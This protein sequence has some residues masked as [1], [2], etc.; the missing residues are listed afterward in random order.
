MR[1]CRLRSAGSEA[2]VRRGDAATKPAVPC[3]NRRRERW[4]RWDMMGFHEVASRNDGRLPS[5]GYSCHGLTSR[6]RY[7]GSN[8]QGDIWRRLFSPCRSANQQAAFQSP[9]SEVARFSG[10]VEIMV[11]SFALLSA[12]DGSRCK[13]S[14]RSDVQP[15]RILRREPQRRYVGFATVTRYFHRTVCGVSGLMGIVRRAHPSAV[16]S[17]CDLAP[18]RGSACSQAVCPSISTAT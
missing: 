5:T 1:P 12:R 16:I 13:V 9:D 4:W 3:T 6:N 15:A 10:L 8:C 14:T 18:G 2:E 7:S 11:E 17:Q